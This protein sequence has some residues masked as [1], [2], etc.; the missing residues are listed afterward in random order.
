MLPDALIYARYDDGTHVSVFPDRVAAGGAVI[1][2]ADFEAAFQLRGSGTGPVFVG[3]RDDVQVL[4]WYRG[5]GCHIAH[6]LLGVSTRRGREF[7]FVRTGLGEGSFDLEGVAAP[8]PA[9]MR[10]SRAE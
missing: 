2:P 3:P 7:R 5:F 1:R 9:E 4:A 10:R 8:P 6:C